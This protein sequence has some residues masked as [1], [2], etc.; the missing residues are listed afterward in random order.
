M[1]HAPRLH[2]CKVL[3]NEM[4]WDSYFTAAELG[5]EGCML[6]AHPH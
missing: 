2:E 6:A 1:E 5:K 4:S 3:G